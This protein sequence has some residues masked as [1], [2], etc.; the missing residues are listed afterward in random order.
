MLRLST[1]SRKP[2]LVLLLA[3]AAAS[4]L[5]LGSSPSATGAALGTSA[6]RE[7]RPG[8]LRSAPDGANPCASMPCMYIAN[9]GANSI[10]EFPTNANGD[11]APTRTVRGP[12][13]EL[14]SPAGIAVDVHR[15]IYVA[16]PGVH[17]RVGVTVYASGAQGDARPIQIIN[18][19]STKLQG[20][21][22]VG[23][24]AQGDIFV[25]NFH[26]FPNGSVCVFAAGSNGNVAPLRRIFGS[27]TGLHLPVA[28]AVDGSGN[29][30]IANVAGGPSST[31][32]ITVYAAG[33][34]GNVAPIQAIGGPSTGV[35]NPG[36]IAIDSSGDT[37][38][39][40][41]T[42]VTVFAPGA[43]GNIAPIQTIQGSST[44]IGGPRGIALDASRNI[45]VV[46]GNSSILVF[47]SGA[48]GN[49]TPI[50]QIAGPNTSL[51]APTGIAIY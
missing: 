12:N 14:T 45:Y 50:Q 6:G 15:R 8:E 3:I 2:F 30:F 49:V 13:T 33:A 48:S 19:R 9:T 24:D 17:P 18:G 28:I 46:N 34:K 29:S 32:G 44:L 27:R 23:L 43:S 38:V 37:Y 26:R 42:S 16:N 36:A 11:V 39:A 40:N 21:V 22:G 51:G 20:P 4:T 47:A 5:F 10:L 31:G 1:S 7:S 41:E 35:D 25:A